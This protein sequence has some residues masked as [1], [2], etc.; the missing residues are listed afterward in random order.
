VRARLAGSADEN[1]GLMSG[2]SARS[3]TAL[4][5][6]ATGKSS[7]L[8]FQKCS[9]EKKNSVTVSVT[10]FDI[11]EYPKF[12]DNYFMLSEGEKKEKEEKKG[13]KRREEREEKKRE[14][15]ERREEREEK[16][17]ERRKERICR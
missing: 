7:P 2:M 10:G 15:E 9:V 1:I 17:R 3:L 5:H 6:V 16:E 14:R 4:R 13:R 8:H 11:T 12:P